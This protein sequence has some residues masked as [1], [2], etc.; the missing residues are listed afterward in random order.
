M[1]RVPIPA[2]GRANVQMQIFERAGSQ[3]ERRQRE[4]GLMNR[5]FLET[6]FTTARPVRVRVLTWS[7]VLS[8]SSERWLGARK[9]MHAPVMVPRIRA[10]CKREARGSTASEGPGARM[11]LASGGAGMAPRLWR[12][13]RARELAGSSFHACGWLPV[14]AADCQ[15]DRLT[16][17]TG[18]P[19]DT[20]KRTVPR[21]E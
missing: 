5:R 15:C 2:T 21:S 19:L 13:R 11:E 18:S 7:S 20:G 1:E 17:A 16:R 12:R 9:L 6:W 14:E 3:T 8:P 10:P 4:R